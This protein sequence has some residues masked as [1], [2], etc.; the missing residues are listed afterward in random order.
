MIYLLLDFL[1]LHIIIQYT[2]DFANM[3]HV[4]LSMILLV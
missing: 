2:L 1:F 3:T 4:I